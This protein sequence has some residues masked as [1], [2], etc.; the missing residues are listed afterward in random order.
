MVLTAGLVGV[1]ALARRGSLLFY[2]TLSSDENLPVPRA[3][4][5]LPAAALLG[6]LLGMTVW[7]GPLARY[8]DATAVQLLTPQTYIDAVLGP[9]P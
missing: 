7:A 1:I 8:A 6:T 3:T 5:W 4:D 2:R 9:R